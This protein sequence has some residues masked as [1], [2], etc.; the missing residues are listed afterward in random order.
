MRSERMPGGLGQKGPCRIKLLRGAGLNCFRCSLQ[1][2]RPRKGGKAAFMGSIF[3]IVASKVTGK[4]RACG[5][6]RG[7]PGRRAQGWYL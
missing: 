4:V 7:F 2:G 1:A 6:G 3:N 5:P